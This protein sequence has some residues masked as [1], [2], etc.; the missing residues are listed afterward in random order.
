MR[1]KEALEAEKQRILKD[2]AHARQRVAQLAVQGPVMTETGS[3]QP[4][5]TPCAWSNAKLAA[6]SSHGETRYRSQIRAREAD[7]KRLIAEYIQLTG[8]PPP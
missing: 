7:I 2:L 5:G 1:L 8:E 3:M 4:D 6:G